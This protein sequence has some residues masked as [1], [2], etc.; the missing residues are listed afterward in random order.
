MQR[1]PVGIDEAPGPTGTRQEQLGSL[2][3]CLFFIYEALLWTH[4]SVFGSDEA[5]LYPD[6]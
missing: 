4:S 2:Q 6:R 3:L 1:G 5:L